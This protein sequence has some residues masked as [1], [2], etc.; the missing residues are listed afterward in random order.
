MAD[1]RSVIEATPDQ[2]YA[3]LADGWNY[4][5]WVVG[6]VH[7][8]AVDKG[9]PAPGSRVHHCVGAWPL[10]IADSTEVLSCDR[11]GSMTLKARMWPLGEATVRL[12]WRADGPNRTRVSMREE[13]ASGPLLA[14][15]TRIND[16]VLHQRNA[17]SL[18]RLADMTKRY[19]PE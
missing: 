3:V 17:E 7:I 6:A 11:T 5:D 10:T 8:R 9:W 15:K 13:F 18:R 14:L 16:L 1:T 4:A 19:R 2:V 12:D